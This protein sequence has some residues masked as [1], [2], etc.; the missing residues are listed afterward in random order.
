MRR[1]LAY[2]LDRLEWHLKLLEA[3]LIVRDPSAP[4]SAEAFDGLRMKIDGEYKARRRH[5]AQLAEL[6]RIFLATDDA[7]VVGARIAEFLQAEGVMAVTE[8]STELAEAFET[9]GPVGPVMVVH[10]PAYIEVSES[11]WSSV[12]L[13]TAQA[14]VAVPPEPSDPPPSDDPGDATPVP[15][16]EEVQG[17]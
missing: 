5:I 16:S 7:S 8:W 9:A 4:K 17:E 2:L 3:Y 13:G 6:D 14:A 12:K 10:S 1:R 15:E 11:S